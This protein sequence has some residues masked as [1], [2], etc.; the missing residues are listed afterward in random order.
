MRYAVYIAVPAGEDTERIA[1][2]VAAAPLPGFPF[3]LREHSDPSESSDAELFFRVAGVEA[4]EEALERALQLYA[5]G[6]ATAGLRPDHAAQPSLVPL[7][8]AAV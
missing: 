6:R 3:Q 1:D 8:R 5:A 2:A 4:P 7:P